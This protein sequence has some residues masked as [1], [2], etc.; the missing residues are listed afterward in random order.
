MTDK[1]YDRTA[2]VAYVYIEEKWREKLAMADFEWL[3]LELLV[4]M[5][6]ICNTVHINIII[7]ITNNN[8]YIQ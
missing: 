8:I 3:Y 4:T 2:Y 7:A 5:C 1:N 6:C